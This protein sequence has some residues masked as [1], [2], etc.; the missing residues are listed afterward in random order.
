MPNWLTEGWSRSADKSQK[1]WISE[2]PMRPHAAGQHQCEIR[3][4]RRA[5]TPPVPWES[6]HARILKWPPRPHH[7]RDGTYWVR[8]EVFTKVRSTSRPFGRHPQI[9]AL[10]YPYITEAWCRKQ[11]K[12]MHGHG[13][14]E[15]QSHGPNGGAGLAELEVHFVFPMLLLCLSRA[16]NCAAGG[17]GLGGTQDRSG[18]PTFGVVRTHGRYGEVRQVA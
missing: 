2:T 11:L 16:H 18:T 14:A 13:R 5:L 3:L 10:I 4:Q 6:G 1:A 7:T 9:F 8:N 15:M 17:S 12:Q